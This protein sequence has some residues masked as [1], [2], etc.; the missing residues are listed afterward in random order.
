MA[1]GSKDY[2]ID[3]N[4]FIYAYLGDDISRS[5]RS[6]RLLDQIVENRSL[7]PTPPNA[8]DAE[9]AKNLDQFSAPPAPLRQIPP[10]TE[11]SSPRSSSERL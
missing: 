5:Q 11:T 10:R 6:K 1:I 7:T 3:T 8:K 4:I 9:T 2:L